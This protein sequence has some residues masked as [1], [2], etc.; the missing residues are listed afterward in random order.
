MTISEVSKMFELSAH[1]L[2]YYEKIGLLRTV[3]KTSSGVRNYKDEDLQRIQFIKCMKTAG[4]SLSVLKIYIELVN[5]GDSTNK[6][7]MDLLIEEKK[8]L[9]IHAEEINSSIGVVNEKIKIYKNL[10][11]EGK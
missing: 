11:K 1:T 9:E 3:E 10:L 2:R 4:V 8:K 7:R 6:Q 5:Q